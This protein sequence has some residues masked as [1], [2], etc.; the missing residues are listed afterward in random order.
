MKNKLTNLIILSISCLLVLFAAEFMFRVIFYKSLLLGHTTTEHKSFCEY[1][2]LLGWRHK[3]NIKVNFVTPEYSSLLSFNSKGHRGP[4]VRYD[5][6]E[7]KFRILILGDSFAEGYAVEFEDLFSEILRKQLESWTGEDIEVINTGVGGYSTDQ[8]LL[9][10]TSEGNKYNPDLTVLLFYENDVFYNNSPKY[11]RGFKPCFVARDYGLVLDNFP[12]PQPKKGSLVKDTLSKSYLLKHLYRRF[13]KEAMPDEDR[14]KLV[15]YDEDTDK[16]WKITEKL[17]ERLK[18][19]VTLI[20]SKLLVVHI[21]SREAVYKE[22]QEA[23]LKHYSLEE[24][25]IDFDKPRRFIKSI[26][27]DNSIDFLSPEEWL[28]YY[29][30]LAYYKQDPHLNKS[31]NMALGCLLTEYVFEEYFR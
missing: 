26:C 15:R 11:W 6:P 27:E 12:V 3:S 19:N 17:I 10:F 5:N 21:P 25:D 30:A 7:D 31:G 9:F 24:S 13:K 1:D 28:I 8:E 4:D 22:F 2:E 14:V 16:A 20:G 29:S 18:T 23:Y